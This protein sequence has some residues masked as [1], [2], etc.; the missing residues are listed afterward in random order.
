MKSARHLVVDAGNSRVKIGV[1]E[2]GRLTDW[3][4][5]PLEEV[6]NWQ[7]P[8]AKYGAFATVSVAEAVLL[9]KMQAAGITQPLQL[10]AGDPLPFAS[11]YLSPESLGQ[12]RKVNIVAALN[13]FPGQPLLVIS[14]GSCITYDVID[15]QGRHLG[16]DIAPGYQMRLQAMHTF[17]QRLPRAEAEI[18]DI[19][20]GNSTRTALQSGAYRGMSAEIN[21]RIADFEAVIPDLKI[22]LTGGDSPFF[23]KSL[24]KQIF[25]APHLALYGL[26]ALLE[27]NFLPG[28]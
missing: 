11:S 24:R 21:G 27:T 20:W 28:K 22:I 12:D 6:A 2:A 7:L 4:Q 8:P 1:F 18:P 26:N 17:T 19:P 25:V 23:E 9:A 16:G 5:I 15:K 13:Q 10:Q 3:Q 14:L